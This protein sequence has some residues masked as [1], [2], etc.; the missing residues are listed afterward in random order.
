MEAEAD[1]FKKFASISNMAHY[2]M[3]TSWTTKLNNTFI[4]KG[5]K[6]LIQC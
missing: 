3:L 2:R 5:N 4:Y 1:K 6:T